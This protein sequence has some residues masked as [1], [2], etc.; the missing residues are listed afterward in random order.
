MSFQSWLKIIFFCERLIKKPFDNKRVEFHWEKG[1]IFKNNHLKNVYNEFH[2][3]LSMLLLRQRN[4]NTN[5][6]TS[7]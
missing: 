3:R 6:K 1:K 4:V 2:E 7:S 5:L